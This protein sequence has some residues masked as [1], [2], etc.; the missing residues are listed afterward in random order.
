MNAYLGHKVEYR[1]CRMGHIRTRKHTGI[2]ESLI[3]RT[4]GIQNLKNKRSQKGWIEQNESSPRWRERT[5]WTL[6]WVGLAYTMVLKKNYLTFFF[7]ASEEKWKRCAFKWLKIQSFIFKSGNDHLY[8]SCDVSCDLLIDY[9][10]WIT[11]DMAFSSSCIYSSCQI[12]L[13]QTWE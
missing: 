13:Y 1:K 12:R 10:N 9:Q 7:T 2:P 6:F 11:Q 5:R 4:N 3:L 8:W